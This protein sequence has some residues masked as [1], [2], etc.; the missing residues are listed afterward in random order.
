MKNILLAIA[1]TASLLGI[2]SA[3]GGRPPHERLQTAVDS[4]NAYFASQAGAT[5]PGATISYDDA[6][7]TVTISYGLP[8]AQVAEF[9]K[10]NIGVAEDILLREVLPEAPC[11]LMEEI[12]RADA[13][14]MIVYHWKPDGHSEHTIKSE[15]I[16]EACATAA[17]TQQQ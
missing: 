14:V 6:S 16:K 12:S 11:R 7:N 5:A 1:L 3:C 4:V 10:E 8:S 9:F 17:A 2:T 13:D 15:R